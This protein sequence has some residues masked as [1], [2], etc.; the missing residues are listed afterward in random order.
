MVKT[1]P[2]AAIL[3]ADL[4]GYSRRMKA[5]EAG[6][7]AILGRALERAR[8]CSRRF[9]GE[10]VKTTGDGWIALFNGVTAAVDCAVVL[11]RMMARGADGARFRVSVHLGEVRREWGDVFGHS[12]NVAVRMQTLAEPG[13]IVVSQNVVA[14]LD[15]SPRYRF[16]TI[17]YP[18]LKNIGDDIALYR[19][20]AVSDRSHTNKSPATR[21]RLQV[22][23]DVRISP[24]DGVPLDL[25]SAHA[26]ALL[27]VLALDPNNSVGTDRLAVM[28]W[29]EKPIVRARANLARTRRIVNAKLVNVVPNVVI[30]RGAV[31]SLD[32]MVE[33]DLQEVRRALDEGSVPPVLQKTSN[34]PGELLAGLGSISSVFQAWLAV[35]QAIWSDRIIAG[36][37]LCL[38]RHAPEQPALRAAAEALLR[39]EPGHEPASLALMRHLAA[40]GRKAAALAEFERINRHLRDNFGAAPS[41]AAVELAAS[42][43]GT[44]S[45]P[46][47]PAVPATWARIPQIA[48]GTFDSEGEAVGAVAAQFR[49][50]LIANLARFHNWAVLDVE[51]GDPGS[52]DYAV[53]GRCEPRGG[54]DRLTLRLSDPRSH[55]IVWSEGFVLSPTTW[56]TQQNLVVGRV[57]SALEIYISADRLLRSVA[58]VPTEATDYDDW[59]RGESLLLQW[60]PE[61]EAEAEAIFSRLVRRAP[62]YAPAHASLASIYNVRHI[63][64]PGRRR[65]RDDDAAGHASATR[66]VALDPMDARNHLA[67]AWSAALTNRFD[68]AAVHLDLAASLNPFS[69]TTMISAAMGYAFLG[70]H[71]RAGATL[72]AAIRLSPMLRPHQWC[73]A[74]AVRFLGGDPMAAEEAALRSGDQIVDNQGWLA[75]ALVRQGRLTEAR[76]AFDRLMLAV[77]PLWSGERPCDAEAVHDWFVHAYPIR[78]AVDRDAITK[79]LLLARKSGVPRLEIASGPPTVHRTI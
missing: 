53:T 12:V 66:A 72:D 19:A 71:P 10:V 46:T 28:L 49:V 69:P 33:T 4:A 22:I 15:R 18:L 29:P 44:G 25:H 65:T 43:R 75:V 58:G 9:G 45:A 36:L 76:E 8:R 61:A 73:Y 79:A 59:L 6:T 62:N 60:T 64:Q 52:A 17:G 74:A 50:E 27:G 70:D 21:L 7:V 42:I 47:T 48:V 24:T 39:L 77:A 30:A 34:V 56:L 13:G 54:E 3:V 41:D 26:A 63:L 31:L 11:Q 37:E 38:E 68:Q 16:E 57:A 78:H 40:R 20:H 5:D 55:R 51:E 1:M 67:L 2:L 23:G 35:Q 32:P 14:E